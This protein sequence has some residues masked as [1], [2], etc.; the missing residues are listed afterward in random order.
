MGTATPEDQ[1]AEFQ[2]VCVPGGSFSTSIFFLLLLDPLPSAGMFGLVLFA[3]WEPRGRNSL[4]PE[5]L[6]HWLLESVSVAK[7]VKLRLGDE[8]CVRACV[9]ASVRACVRACLRACVYVCV[10]GGGGGK[11]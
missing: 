7:I 5:W 10:G 8:V 3:D 1:A 2:L 6:V 4:Y 11:C 9:R